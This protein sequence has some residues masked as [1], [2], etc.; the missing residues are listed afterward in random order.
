MSLWILVSP[1]QLGG[2]L[3]C[4][5]SPPVVLQQQRYLPEP[6]TLRPTPKARSPPHPHRM[7]TVLSSSLTP[8]AICGSLGLQAAALSMWMEC[9]TNS[10]MTSVA[11][12]PGPGL[13]ETPSTLRGCPGQWTL[14]TRSEQSKPHPSE[15]R[16]AHQSWAHIAPAIT[17]ERSPC[18]DTLGTFLHGSV[19]RTDL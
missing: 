16:S 19:V 15:V 4:F 11:R 14:P 2:S 1:Y 10:A 18:P 7:C 9:T 8:L 12:G 13:P 5:G 3:G 17:Q 6:S